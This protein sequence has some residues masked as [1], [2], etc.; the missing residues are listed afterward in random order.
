MN[1]EYGMIRTD[2]GPEFFP[3]V[4]DG[5]WEEAV[6][7]FLGGTNYTGCAPTQAERAAYDTYL[8]SQAL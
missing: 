6:T 2:N 3:I 4:D 5:D 8:A 1:N 7:V